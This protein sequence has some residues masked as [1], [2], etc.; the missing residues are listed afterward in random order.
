MKVIDVKRLL[1]DIRKE[2]DE[3]AHIL[4]DKMFVKVLKEIACGAVNAQALAKEAL[5]SQ[6]ISFCRWYA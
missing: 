1:K 2:D 6:K 5:K 4:E 3:T